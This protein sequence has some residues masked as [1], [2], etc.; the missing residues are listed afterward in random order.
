MDMDIGSAEGDEGESHIG[1]DD[2]GDD[3]D[4]G[5]GKSSKNSDPYFNEEGGVEFRNKT[6]VSERWISRNG[7]SQPPTPKLN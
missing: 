7:Y 5:D 4:D 6:E 3:D 2:D 1:K